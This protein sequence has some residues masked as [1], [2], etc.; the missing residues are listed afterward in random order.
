M[1]KNIFL[2]IFCFL[3]FF[4]AVS[5][6][7]AREPSVYFS[8]ETD[9]SKKFIELI[10]GEPKKIR[11]VTEKLSDREVI[12]ALIVAHKRGVSI[13]VIVDP[14]KV[15]ARSP[16][17][18]LINEKIPVFVW[19]P[20]EAFSKA[21]KNKTKQRMHQV[22][23]I[24]GSSL[25]WTGSYSFSLKKLV[26]HRENALVLRDEKVSTAFISEFEKMKAT[27]AITLLAY[28]EG[29]KN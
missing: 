23:C 9:L 15:T 1:R 7:S 13:E 22:F 10:K 11:L 18:L 12:R 21:Q 6:E 4:E 27:N 3:P 14:V 29:R 28:L 19:Q 25:S 17:S 16:L 5:L 20:D 24:F 8:S 2:C 26:S